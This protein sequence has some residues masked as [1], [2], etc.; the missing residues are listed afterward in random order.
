MRKE[1]LLRAREVRTLGTDV[2]LSS[3]VAWA[4]MGDEAVGGVG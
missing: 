1:F 3:G 4:Q 2:R